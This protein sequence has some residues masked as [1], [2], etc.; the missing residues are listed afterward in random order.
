M[1]YERKAQI[2]AKFILEFLYLNKDLILEILCNK[3]P[4]FE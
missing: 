1:I 3:D 4:F 2:E